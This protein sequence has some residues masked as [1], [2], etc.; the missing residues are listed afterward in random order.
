MSDFQTGDLIP[1]APPCPLCGGET[2]L[3]QMHNAVAKVIDVFRCKRCDVEYPMV[4]KSG[5]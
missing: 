4:R 3:R 1:K 2:F 5:G